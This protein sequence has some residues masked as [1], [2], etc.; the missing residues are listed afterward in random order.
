[1]V[2]QMSDGSMSDRGALAIRSFWTWDQC[3]SGW[4]A[5]SRAAR[6]V[7]RTGADSGFATRFC[8]SVAIRREVVQFLAAVAVA[9]VD[10][11]VEDQ[12]IHRATEDRRSPV[13]RVV[14][15]RG[16]DLGEYRVP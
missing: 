8:D 1:M 16:G 14:F 2:P 9:D 5:W 11:I 12:R 10:L 15:R 3:R 7:V 6:T 13:V 4:R